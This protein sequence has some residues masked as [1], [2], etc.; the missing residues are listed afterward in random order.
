L[1][2]ERVAFLPLVD[3]DTGARFEDLLDV[4]RTRL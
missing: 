4:T 2:E 3:F 1:V